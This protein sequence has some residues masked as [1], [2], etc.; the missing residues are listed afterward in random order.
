MKKVEVQTRKE[1]NQKHHENIFIKGI[2]GW[3]GTY[4]DDLNETR[5]AF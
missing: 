2:K 4:K 1:G 5:K 3:N